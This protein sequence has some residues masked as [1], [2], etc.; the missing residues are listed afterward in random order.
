MRVL[1]ETLAGSRHLQ[2]AVVLYL[3]AQIAGDE[4]LTDDGIP[5]LVVFVLAFTKLLQLVVLMR[6]NVVGGMSAH[7]VNDVVLPEVLL[8]GKNGLEHD[9]ESVLALALLLRMQAVVAVLAVVLVVFLTEVM[10]Q[11]L[12]TAHTRL[13]IGGSLLQQLAT[14]VLLGHGLSLHELLEF[15]QVLIGIEGDADALAAVAAGTSR[16]LIVAFEALRDVVVD[17]EAHIGFVDAHAKSNGGDDDVD[18]LH[19]E[20]VLRLGTC[21]RVEACMIGGSLDVVGLQHGCQLLH[22]LSRKTIDDAALAGILL[23]ETD[24]L[25]VDVLRLLPHLVIKVRAVEGALEL[26]GSDD[27][28]TLLDIGAHLIGGSSRECDDR[29]IADAVDGWADIAILR[30]EVVS[31][32]RDTVCLVDG[33]ERNLDALEELY[34]LVLVQRLGSHIEQL[35]ATFAH[36]VHH[37]LDGRLV[38]RGVQIVRQALLLAQSI[39]DIHLVFHQGDER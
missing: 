11:H 23:D 31:P 36:I 4:C 35:R 5:N 12:T 21:L 29:G 22:L 15:L 19:Q 13:G 18:A 16:L 14:D 10:Q 20:V 34:I 37:L 33:I 6:N 39:D 30:S 2:Q 26:N 38:Q 8:D 24:D 7:E 1:Q 17:D 28:Q 32:L 3:L 9:D 27:A 25:L